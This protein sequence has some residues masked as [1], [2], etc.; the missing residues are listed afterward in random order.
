VA[1][2]AMGCLGPARTRIPM[3]CPTQRARRQGRRS[4]VG[5]QGENDDCAPPPTRQGLLLAIHRRNA[6]ADP[7]RREEEQEYGEPSD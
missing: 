3:L 5:E 6:I 4:P 2:S 7:A 1:P